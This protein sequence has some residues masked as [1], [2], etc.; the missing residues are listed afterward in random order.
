MQDGKPYLAADLIAQEAR[1]A[2]LLVQQVLGIGWE[3]CWGMDS[4]EFYALLVRARGIQE[5]RLAAMKKAG[6]GVG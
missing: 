2:V 1:D 4:C 6:G 3:E 5:E